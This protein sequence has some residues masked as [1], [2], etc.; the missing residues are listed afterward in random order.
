MTHQTSLAK[1]TRTRKRRRQEMSRRRY[2]LSLLMTVVLVGLALGVARAQ[3]THPCTPNNYSHLTNSGSGMPADY[4]SYAYLPW[5]ARLPEHPQNID[6]ANTTI[7]RQH[8][9]VSSGS[10]RPQPDGSNYYFAQAQKPTQYGQGITQDHPYYVA[11]DSDPLVSVLCYDGAPGSEVS[12]VIYGCDTLNGHSRM[13]ATYYGTSGGDGTA[14]GKHY[15]HIPPYARMSGELNYGSDTYMEIM[16]AN[17]DVVGLL[18]CFVAPSP[19][20]TYVGQPRNWQDG[21]VITAPGYAGSFCQSNFGGAYWGKITDPGNHGGA[22][23]AGDAMTALPSTYKEVTQLLEHRHA[24]HLFASCFCDCTAHF[25][26]TFAGLCEA[27]AGTPGL[28]VG[29]RMWLDMDRAAIDAFAAA[30]PLVIPPGLKVFVYALHEEGAYLLD[31]GGPGP[32]WITQPLLESFLN[33]L[34]SNNI[35]QAPWMGWMQQVAGR[36]DVLAGDLGSKIGIQP[37]EYIDWSNPTLISKMY[38]LQD[39][40]A[41]GTCGDSIPEGQPQVTGPYYISPNG[42][43]GNNCTAAQQSTFAKHT[44]QDDSTGPGVLSC[45]QGG[46]KVIVMDGTYT[47]GIGDGIPSG[48]LGSPTVI[49]TQHT[50]NTGSVILQPQTLPSGSTAIVNVGP[51]TANGKQW[52]TIDG[53]TL[54]GSRL[55][56]G[57]QARGVATGTAS[58]GGSSDLVFSNMEIRALPNHQTASCAVGQESVGFLT[59]G[60]DTRIQLTRSHIDYIGSGATAGQVCSLC[61]G[62][63]GSNS[64]LDGVEVDHCQGAALSRGDTSASGGNNI[65]RNSFFHDSGGAVALACGST[66]NQFYNN[67]L[68]QI[69]RYGVAPQTGTLVL[70]GTCASQTSSGNVLV[71]NTIYHG[72]GTCIQ[73]GTTTGVTAGPSNTNT[74]QNNLCWQNDITGTPS[75]AVTVVSGTGNTID[76]NLVTGS[77]APP[78]G[79]PLFVR[80]PPVTAPDF[81]VQVGPPTS[82]AIDAGVTTTLS[83]STTDY[84]GNPRKQGTQQDVGAWETAGPGSTV[85][86]PIAWWKFEESTGTTAADSTG[87][88]HTLTLSSGVTWGPGQVGSGALKCQGNTGRATTPAFTGLTAYTWMAWIQG[89]ATPTT[90]TASTVFINGNYTTGTGDAFGFVWDH[91]TATDTQ[92]AYHHNVSNVYNIAQIPG[93][94]LSP[95]TWYH[96]ALTFESPANTMRLYVNGAQSTVVQNVGAMIPPTDQ[97]FVCGNAAGAY[98]WSG[99]IDELKLWNRTLSANEVHLEYNGRPL[100]RR[101]AHR[102]IGH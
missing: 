44:F 19:Q 32:P 56:A 49:Q 27:T 61:L 43:N 11:T 76:H 57:Q 39:C 55:P 75:D 41:R 69:G 94:L 7:L 78:Y 47:E 6:T 9:L 29:S 52:I 84:G 98:P 102:A 97:L 40:Y 91:P 35:T 20:G 65:L 31:T 45:L 12:H 23:N 10:A 48:Q 26:G 16:Q 89:V 66:N 87:N 80:S 24:L 64:T 37:G 50:T 92:S 79:D 42:L 62:H 13:W 33:G 101:V 46:Q 67:I 100:G 88:G 72:A 86:G 77:T 83:G 74:I 71:N 53:L 8:Y 63:N 15:F 60:A 90:A 21:D 22:L 3:F 93:A 28:P 17:G 73:V 1:R 95:N 68:S 82:P 14:N 18:G 85:A 5:R 38:I 96:V 30:N 58:G 25:P 2:L 81:Q 59:T 70:G 34:N 54:D 51:Q 99:M 36:T 4:C